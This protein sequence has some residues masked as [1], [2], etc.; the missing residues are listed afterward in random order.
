MIRQSINTIFKFSNCLIIALIISSCNNHSESDKS[1]ADTK[2]IFPEYHYAL[3]SVIKSNNGIVG[4]IELGQGKQV[5]PA[6]QISKAIEKSNTHITFEQKIDS[7]SKYSITYL[8]EN[9]TINEIEVHITST[10]SEEGEKILNDLKKY[11]Q[12]KYTAPMMDKGYFVF[13]CFDS[14]KRNFTI[15]LTD[16]SSPSNSVIDMLVYREK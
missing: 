3:D 7:I 14:N 13:N 16:N 9:D 11:Y 10:N 4:G 1:T 6:M 15:T 5:I 2:R 8:M 12:T